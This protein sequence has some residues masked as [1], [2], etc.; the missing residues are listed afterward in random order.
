MDL[1][2]M[3]E[4]RAYIFGADSE[5]ELSV[6]LKVATAQ[7]ARERAKRLA[8][9]CVVELWEGPTPIARFEPEE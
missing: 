1:S 2:K 8:D 4:F 5:V 9:E 3:Q 6:D 7:Q